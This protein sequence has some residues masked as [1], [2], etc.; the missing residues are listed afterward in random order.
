MEM[1]TSWLRDVQTFGGQR[2]ILMISGAAHQRNI[3]NKTNP[4]SKLAELNS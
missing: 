2:Q 3:G 4:K 1:E